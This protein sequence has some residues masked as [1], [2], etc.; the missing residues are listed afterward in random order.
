MAGQRVRDQATLNHVINNLNIAVLIARSQ[1]LP[2]DAI[3]AD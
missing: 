2:D 3:I 1:R